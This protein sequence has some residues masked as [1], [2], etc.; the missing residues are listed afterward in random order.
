MDKT[1]HPLGS[2][3]GLKC[4][5]FDCLSIALLINYLNTFSYLS[6]VLVTRDIQYMLECQFRMSLI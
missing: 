6:I 4:F 1:S 5:I 3:H 2:S